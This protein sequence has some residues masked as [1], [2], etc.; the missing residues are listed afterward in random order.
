MPVVLFDN[1]SRK[2]LSPLSYTHAT[3]DL[4]VGILT[5]A[6][7]WSLLLK[8]EVFLKTEDYLQPLY[9][10]IP[11]GG[12][13]W[14]DASVLPSKSLVSE[15]M[16]LK[17]DISLG[18]DKGLIAVR[19]ARLP[20][21]L[22]N[23][24]LPSNQPVARLENVL[25][26]FQ[27]NDD[28]LRRD[29]L[30]LTTNRLSV[31]VSSTNKLIGKENIFIEEGAVVEHAIIN[32]AAGPVYIGK[33]AIVMEGSCIRGP[34]ALGEGSVIKM[35]TTV[36]GATTLGPFCTGG[37]EIKNV[38]MQGYSNKAHGGYLGDSVIGNWCNLGAGTSSSNLKNSAGAVRIWDQ[39]SEKFI[40][41]D[42]KCGVIMGD[43]TRTAINSAINTGSYFGVCC[44]VFADGLLPKVIG[45]FSWGNNKRYEFDK[46]L[47]DID[48]WKKLKNQS[49]SGT[50]RAV[51]KYIFE[52]FTK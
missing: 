26:I 11:A 45:N 28:W 12:H 36:Y 27:Q 5:I 13:L 18:D 34:F 52:H 7:R 37:G 22:K 29:F 25:Q 19:S 3:G 44:N 30:L 41:A 31:P 40:E 8:Q 20:A 43:Y 46:S 50:E 48:N 1:L 15:I 49:L 9:K 4:R 33:N 32:A 17:E 39:S 35:G 51:L 24:D 47:Q 21:D 23:Y 16:A 38:V 2:N 6:E 42:Q 14:I 10:K